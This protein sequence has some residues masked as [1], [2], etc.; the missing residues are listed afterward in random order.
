MRATGFLASVAFGWLLAAFPACATGD[1][2]AAK[3]PPR[4]YA[5]PQALLTDGFL[6]AHP[7]MDYRMRGVAL[8]R[9][10][11]PAAAAKEC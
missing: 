11:D 2:E 6:A 9:R 5:I 8:D 4:I 10:G 1:G 3:V 7:D